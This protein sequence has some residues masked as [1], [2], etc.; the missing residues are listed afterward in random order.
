MRSEGLA[1]RESVI[2]NFNNNGI[3]GALSYAD[4]VFDNA[5]NLYGTTYIGGVHYSGTVFELIPKVG[6]GWTEKIL[7]DFN[8]ENGDGC[9]PLAGMTFDKSG[10]LYGTTSEGG[11][12]LGG[13]VVFELI[14]RPSGRWAEKILHRFTGIGGD[15][16]DPYSAG[17]VLDSS[18]NVYGTTNSGGASGAGTI[19]ELTPTAAGG[20]SYAILHSFGD[21]E[22]GQFP[23]AGLILDAQGNL[24]GTTF[25]GGNGACQNGTGPA[26]KLT[27]TAGTC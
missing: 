26:F 6:G 14:P 22:S 2:R 21:R 27:F 10:N 18:G 17:V 9:N 20:W 25:Q 13:G 7:H 11:L 3:D 19:Y 12:P 15:G 24:Y 23:Q 16:F 5:G 1:Q 8:C 4:V